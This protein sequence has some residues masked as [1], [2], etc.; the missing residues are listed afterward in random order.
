MKNTSNLK[1]IFE[2][3]YFVAVDKPGGMLSVPG[4]EGTKDPTPCLW[5]LLN[6]ELK[7]PVY[8]IHRLD[9]CV[10]GV[11]LYAKSVEAERAANKWFENRLVKKIYQAITC[12][13]N[14][15]IDP[16]APQVWKGRLARG[17]KR[18]Y[19]APFGKEAVTHAQ[20]IKILTFANKEYILW[21]LEPL[22]GR[23]HQ[24]RFELAD[25]GFPI[26]GDRLYGSESDFII[27]KTIALRACVLDFSGIK[28]DAKSKDINW[29]L[30]NQIT[31]PGIE[32]LLLA[33]VSK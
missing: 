22:T 11:I 8:P 28:L 32:D 24:L 29:N 30:P 10:S 5:P 14:T 18:A 7:M 33:A 17:K 1:I 25:H 19:R 21:Q 15:L 13:N 3:E 16:L 4:R 12:K 2:N 20:G 31:V 9:V 27:Y 6:E 23:S 26:W